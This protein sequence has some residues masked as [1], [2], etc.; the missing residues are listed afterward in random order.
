MA[1]EE[2]LGLLRQGVGVWN[3]WRNINRSIQP[4][5]HLAVLT[6]TDLHGAI[7]DGARLDGA[8]LH[9]A[10]LHGANLQDADLGGAN[11]RAAILDGACLTGAKL[12]EADLTFAHLDGA[13]LSKAELIGADLLHARLTEVNLSGADLTYARLINSDLRNANLTG[14]RIYGISAWEVQLSGTIQSQLIITQPDEPTITV[15]NLEVAQFIYLLLHN[16]KIRTVIDTITS[17]AVLI[18][19]RFTPARKDVLDGI[20]ETLR[21][22]N[23][24]SILF[25][26]D[27]PTTRDIT[28]TVTLLARM[29]RFIIADLTEPSSIPKELET[30][31]PTL[32]VP[33]QPLLQ[34]SKRAYSM[35]KDYWKYSWV[36][37]VHRYES[38][39]GLLS[40]LREKVIVP[41]EAKAR[42]LEERRRAMEVELMK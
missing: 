13:D 19:G 2:H 18:L 8:D 37:T 5:L 15:D 4:D 35:F 34:G 38:L 33:V 20:R 23:Y 40:S 36:L 27:I 32:A 11:L 24:V 7:L 21:A 42:E 14:C 29:A 41:A 6:G 26:F 10:D 17:K 1:N 30:I 39:E 3:T 31:V 25:D 22:Q 9:E 28:T 16:E 12:C